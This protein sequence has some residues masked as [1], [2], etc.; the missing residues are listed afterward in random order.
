[1]KTCAILLVLAVAAYAEVHPEDFVSSDLATSV[2]SFQEEA[3]EE[4]LLSAVQ[5]LR[6][7]APERVAHHVRA[8]SKHVELLQSTD[9]KSKAYA[10]NFSSAQAAIRAALKS[11]TN[12]LNAGH[13]HDKNAL[14]SSRTAG[15]NAIKS[16]DSKG[17]TTSRNLRH[18]AC[19][20][21]RAEEA[22][23]VR[24]QAA[25][26]KL[27]SHEKVK[28]C[29]TLSTTWDDMDIQ[30]SIPKF[31]TVLRNAWDTAR[32][33][34]VKL[35]GQRD[36]A[37]KAHNAAKATNARTMAAFKTAVRIE[38]AN[39]ETACKNAHTE[40]NALKREVASNV[41][42]RKQTFIATLVITCYIDNITA[43]TS[44]KSCADKKRR[45]S[46]AQWNITPA[47]LQ[48]CASRAANENTYGPL[49]WT[50]VM[51]NCR[52]GAGRESESTGKTTTF[53]SGTRTI[54]R[55]LRYTNSF[56]TSQEY[57]VGVDIYPTKKKSGWHNVIHF[58]KGADGSQYGRVP[59]FWFFSN[60]FRLHM[61]FSQNGNYNNGCDPAKHL[62]ANKWTSVK[63]RVQSAAVK[64]F[65]DGV[66]VCSTK[67]GTLTRGTTG[68]SVYASDNNYHAAG[69]QIRNFYYTKL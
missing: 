26:A 10:H 66:E 35:K 22:A 23:N 53:Q 11:L 59:A 7:A 4:T 58:M 49:N 38:A 19:P 50:P 46:T 20:T 37:I 16:A 69:A 47:A 36:A 18:K 17:K 55:N 12:E 54:T 64:V 42:T 5:E 33:T 9:T 34:W 8:I 61:R 48:G 3:P 14:N 57:E 39:T 32:S 21:Q 29:G 68:V 2:K 31:G 25:Q 62:P 63:M 13:T 52:G 67:P 56:T 45:A 28:F 44:A 51:D 15:T 30:K 24:K 41:H 43:N 27:N 1:M 40:Y 6:R 65:F 60:T